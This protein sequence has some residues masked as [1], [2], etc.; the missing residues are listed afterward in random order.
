MLKFSSFF[1]SSAQQDVD[2]PTKS[3]P[4]F[5]LNKDLRVI[6]VLFLQTFNIKKT[7][8]TTE[9]MKEKQLRESNVKEI[10]KRNKND[11]HF[12]KHGTHFTLVKR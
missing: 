2:I 11:L 1:Y 5:L 8:T 3:K 12:N 9:K 7:T 4:I 10:F 6:N